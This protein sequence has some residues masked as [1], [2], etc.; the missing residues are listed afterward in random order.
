M[1]LNSTMIP[2]SYVI[3]KFKSH[4]IVFL[5]TKHK[6]PQILKFISDLIPTLHEAGVSH[7]CLEIASD[8]QG[9]INHYAHTGAGLSKIDVAHPID[10]PE[11]RNL[12]QTIHFLPKKKQITPVAIDLPRSKFTEKISRDE[13]MAEAIAGLLNNNPDKKM[14]VVLGNLHVLKKL[15]WEDHVT[16]KHPSII[17]SLSIKFPVSRMFCV[18]QLIGYNPDECDF[19]KA[20]SNIN[21]AVALDLTGEFYG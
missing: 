11:Y 8:Q 15:E 19:T 3:E 1:H 18:G 9:K 4:D 10:C 5:G 16:N 7:I 21:G 13:Y 6:Q 2:T 14:L 17:E 20:F 12:L